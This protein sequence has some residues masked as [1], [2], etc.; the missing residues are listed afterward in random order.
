MIAI[1]GSHKGQLSI[2]LAFAIV[3]FLVVVAMIN[4][5]YLAASGSIE[6]PRTIA[7][8]NSIRYS[9]AGSID[10]FYYTLPDSGGANIS[11]NMPD[12]YTFAPTSADFP[13]DLNPQNEYSINYTVDFDTSP[14]LFVVSD[15]KGISS[16]RR[17]FTFDLS[18]ASGNL[19]TA[20][21]GQ[22]L[23]LS[24]CVLN[25]PDVDCDNCEI[26]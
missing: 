10:A 19:I 1:I 5:Q 26:I 6:S 17:T 15:T 23:I 21:P 14:F 11:L 12:R 3:L 18:C 24:G 16:Q 8:I 13:Y 25:G 7:A 20:L 2:D 22:D 9:L 4:D